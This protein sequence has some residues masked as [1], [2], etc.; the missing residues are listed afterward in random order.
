[1]EKFFPFSSTRPG[2]D[3]FMDMISEALKEEKNLVVHAPTGI[4]KTVSALAPAV[5][6]A[7]E[8]GKTVVFLT[9]RHMQH[10]IVIETL[11]SI[12]E[13]NPEADIHVANIVGKRWL[14]RYEDVKT[15][16]SEKVS[17]FCKKMKEGNNC[18]YYK[19]IFK[20]SGDVSEAGLSILAHLKDEI[21][22]S[23]DARDLCESKNMC[24]YE[25][26]ML[27]LKEANVIIADYY[28]MLH[29]FV[30]KMFLSK[31]ERDMNDIILIID[32][33]HN[34]PG[35]VRELLSSQ[36]TSEL[37]D[38][39][40]KEAEKFNF[41]EI[42]DDFKALKKQVEAYCI[43]SVG[44]GEE[45]T[46]RKEFLVN[47]VK[48]VSGDINQ[49]INELM[50]AGDIVTNDRKVSYIESVGRFLM[51]WCGR[52]YGF[53]RIVRLKRGIDGITRF[54]V[55]Y[56]CL[57]PSML[58]KDLFG[59]MH[60]TILMSGTLTPIDMFMNVLGLDEETTGSL[61][62]DSPFPCE[63]RLI[64]IKD[65]VT[66]KFTERS[67]DQ[68]YRIAGNIV[69]VINN[70]PGNIGIFF[71][72]YNMMETIGGLMGHSVVDK[73]IVT[74]RQDMTKL[75]KKRLFERFSSY[76]KK[77]NGAALFAVVGANFSEGVDFPGELMNAVVV[78][79]L[80]LQKPDIKNQALINYYDMRFQ[81]GWEYGYIY[82]A[83]NKVMQTAGRCIRSETDRGVIIL[84]DKRFLWHPYKDLL[85]RDA[86]MY[87]SGTL[88]GE[89]EEFF[90]I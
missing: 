48:N 19:K 60:S 61:V 56:D 9:P 10:R 81:K 80:P 3:R 16:S 33:A 22:T 49:M 27:H 70:I 79:G 57:D 14:C 58:T 67:E 62:L 90:R 42:H 11:K 77:G 73:E 31:L 6:H 15:M 41:K 50:V 7:V 66:T 28:H 23:E 25:M 53:T 32:E 34:V 38:K 87:I 39:A 75:D 76:V 46:A 21:M 84:M 78:V 37:M 18:I 82:P 71:P 43:K 30:Q 51:T 69:K 26:L 74:E 24:T 20:K 68:F 86:Q 59:R 47:I 13:K 52:D 83:M 36:L 64:L 2:Q 88:Q 85:P 17:E 45:K 5:R 65:D 1:M 4:G 63:N 29:P 8:N 12:K 89:L 72:S 55:R 40:I 44:K 54:E 35:R